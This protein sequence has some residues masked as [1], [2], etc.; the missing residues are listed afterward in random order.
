M[1]QV[2]D[3][4]RVFCFFFFSYLGCWGFSLIGFWVLMIWH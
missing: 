1:Y 3:S 4:L 2:L